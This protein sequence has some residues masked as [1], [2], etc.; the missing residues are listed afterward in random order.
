MMTREQILDRAA[1]ARSPRSAAHVVLDSIVNTHDRP[2][3]VS[4]E[5]T[6]CLLVDAVRAW[7]LRNATARPVHATPGPCTVSAML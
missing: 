6:K 5:A 2:T 7:R 4:L 3:D 1:D